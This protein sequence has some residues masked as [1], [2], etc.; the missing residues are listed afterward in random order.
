MALRACPLTRSQAFS[1]LS[2]QHRH[3]GVP[4]AGFRYAI[5]ALSKGV[6]VGV[7]IVGRPSARLLPAYTEAEVT[8]LCTDGTKNACSFLYARAAQMTRLHGFDRVYTYI[9][10]EET[11][12]SLKAAGW[13][14]EYT[15]KGGGRDRPSR[16]R[17]D[18]SP[19]C[20]KQRW[21]PRW[22]ATAAPAAPG[23]APPAGSARRR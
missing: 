3:H 13:V 22:C 7:V 18:H 20:P 8:R 6:L 9:L 12:A 1:Y 14:Y 4:P 10:E 19:V 11:G 16:R 17:A 15:T 5:G 21:A 2:A 23:A